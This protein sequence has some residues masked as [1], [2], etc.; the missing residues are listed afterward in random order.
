MKT[1]VQPGDVI[2]MT[3][4]AN[5]AAGALIRAGNLVGVAVAD[6]ASG[7]EGAARRSGVVDVPK[8]SGNSTSMAVGDLVYVSQTNAGVTSSS[9]SNALVGTV[10]RAAANADTTVRVVMAQ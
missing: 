8:V 1:Y 5:V 9:T 7:V 3:P 10:V 2:D 4:A 6:I